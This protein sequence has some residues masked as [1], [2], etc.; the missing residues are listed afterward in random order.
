MSAA[1]PTAPV[2]LDRHVLG[3]LKFIRS[4]IESA[5]GF[6]V[7]GTAGIAMGTIGLLAMAAAY[8]WKNYW[9]AIWI[10]AANL[11]LVVGGYLILRRARRNK[12]PLYRA[13]LRRF[14]LCLCPTLVAGA[15]LTV[16][17]VRTSHD[18]YLAGIWLLLYGSAV[19]SASAMTS[20]GTDKLIAAMAALFM[21]F[22]VIAFLLPP[23]LQTLML[24]L[25]FGGL[26]IAFGLLI[27][28]TSHE[29]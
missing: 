5:G 20:T 16:L 28:R 21:S 10:A 4:S 22:G 29:Q 11:A 17:L 15:I 25:G 6:D 7:P 8:S 19:L 24:G 26:H 9:L 27:A 2:A 23:T 1:P 18:E 12:L 13:P 14:L 3:T